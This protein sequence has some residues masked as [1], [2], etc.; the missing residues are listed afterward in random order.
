M[1]EYTVKIPPTSV[2]VAQDLAELVP[3]A[4]KPIE[5]FGLELYQTSDVGDAAEKILG[6]EVIV[7]NT[8][9][10]S[11]GTAPTPQPINPNDA[12]AAFTAKVNNTTQASAG[13]PSTVHSGGWNTRAGL[14][15]WW[16]TGSGPKASAAHSRIRIAQTAPGDAI[17]MGG[18]VY[19][20]ELI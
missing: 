2:S 5:I 1:R 16:P 4:N 7:G 18:T 9:S 12:A 19:V 13:S 11:G 20:R 10:G 17:T 8:T 6:V 3:G 15:L 14:A